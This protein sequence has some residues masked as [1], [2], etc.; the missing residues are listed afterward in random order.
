MT[1]NA[2]LKDQGYSWV[3]NS[4]PGGPGHIY[5]SDALLA[6]KGTI[7]VR[8]MVRETYRAAYQSKRREK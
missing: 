1:V 3:G 5:A 7:H 2:Y 4:T 6:Q 8:Q